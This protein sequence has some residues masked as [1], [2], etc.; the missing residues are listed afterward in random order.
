MPWTL[1]K[2]PIIWGKCLETIKAIMNS[3][4]NP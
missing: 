1:Y 4:K 3:L 2:L